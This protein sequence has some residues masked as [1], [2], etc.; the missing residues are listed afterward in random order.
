MAVAIVAAPVL[1]YNLPGADGVSLRSRACGDELRE[2]EESRFADLMDPRLARIREVN[3]RVIRRI[4][5]M[6]TADPLTMS[7][8]KIFDP[9]PRPVQAPVPV[10]RY[11]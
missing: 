10:G 11:R 4:E 1:I 5:E 7:C 9:L 8:P 6:M 3:Q 2:K